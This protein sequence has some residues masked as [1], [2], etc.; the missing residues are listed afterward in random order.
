MK[1]NEQNVQ[2]RQCT[3]TEFLHLL[4]CTRILQKQI[5]YILPLL[6]FELCTYMYVFLPTIPEYCVCCVPAQFSGLSRN[7]LLFHQYDQLVSQ[8]ALAQN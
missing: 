7:Y 3:C 2:I 8:L 6:E 1:T 5:V 4:V